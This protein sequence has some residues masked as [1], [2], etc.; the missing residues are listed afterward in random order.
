MARARGRL[1]REQRFAAQLS[2]VLAGGLVSAPVSL[3]VDFPAFVRYR[4]L[5]HTG[6]CLPCLRQVRIAAGTWR[7]EPCVRLFAQGRAAVGEHAQDAMR[8]WAF[9]AL[10]SALLGISCFMPSRVVSALDIE[11]SK[12]AEVAATP[13]IPDIRDKSSQRALTL[14][15]A[16]RKRKAIMFGAYWCPY[17][18]QERQALGKDVFAEGEADASG[19]K[20]RPMV[21]YVEC[22]AKGEG[23]RL[24]LCAF[25]G[26]RSYPTWA[27]S[28]DSRG[29]D[30]PPYKLYPGARGLLGL[31]RLTGL[32]P[33]PLA[34]PPPVVSVSGAREMKVAK[35]LASQGA[36]MY[37]TW[38]CR[39][40]DAQRQLF[41]Q[42]AW[43]LVPYVECDA[44]SPVGDP[45]ECDVAGV[46]AFPEW[47]LPDGSHQRGLLSLDVLEDVLFPK[48]SFASGK[49][50]NSVT[51]LPMPDEGNCE[52]CKL[53]LPKNP[54]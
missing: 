7:R 51:V 46:E 43:A 9:V 54:P 5:P 29:P 28:D 25:A 14:G 20:Q 36:T 53:D 35:A 38:W 24:D 19:L 50:A 16:L 1:N 52:D 34:Q 41:G 48:G 8:R 45:G 11:V 39:F 21:R 33:E 10:A 23:A 49:T 18:D 44:R 42:Q 2:F 30:G 27:F 4:W 37:G 12:P 15:E 6:C 26:V 40:C 47:V 3:T 22:D 31:E 13:R 32:A 17:C